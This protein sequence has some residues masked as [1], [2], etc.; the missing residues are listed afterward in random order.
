MNL[1]LAYQYGLE[2]DDLILSSIASATL[3]AGPDKRPGWVL[4]VD[5]GAGVTD[6]VLYYGWKCHLYRGDSGWW[7][8]TLLV[9]SPWV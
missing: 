6:I 4:V 5:I 1:D 3:V 8:T 2:V 9:I 7:E